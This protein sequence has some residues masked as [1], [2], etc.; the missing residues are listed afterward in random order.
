[1]LLR[2]TIR[3][4]PTPEQELLFRK[5]AGVAR[6]AYNFYISEQ[7]RTYQEYLT[8]NK[9]GNK[10]ISPNDVK[11][12]INNILKPTIEYQWLK[13]VGCNV[14]KQGVTDAFNAYKKFYN[15]KSNKPK[16]HSKRKNRLSFYVNYESLTK[17]N[18]GF[19]GECIGFIK[20]SEA[21]PDLINQKHYS[22][23]R[24]YYDNKYWYLSIAIDEPIVPCELT[25]EKLGIDLGIKDL[26]ICSNNK[27]YKNINKTHRV[28][29]IKKKLK[30]AQKKYSRKVLYNIKAYDKNR[31]PI[32]NRSLDE[33]KNIQKQK[34]TIQLLNRRLANIRHNYLHQVTTEIVKT[35]PSRIV[36]EDL[37]IK[38]MMKNRHLSKSIGE[39]GLYCFKQMIQYKCLKYGIEFC[40]VPTFYPSSKTCSHCGNIK[41]DLKL[42]DRIYY[43][44]ECG[45][46]IDRD[47]NAAINLANYIFTESV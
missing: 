14:I 33:C 37:N 41:K 2:K 42:S 4:K 21:L 24:I 38:G 6:W 29:K 12:Y 10:T 36:M 11:K 35:K 5:S 22:D 3:L 46:I 17:R 18:G 1:M 8:N 28:K 34:Y 44:N 15:G 16:Y 47:Y 43:C 20:T 19:H 39:Q 7:E 40:Q 31:K 13:D 27:K 9:T 26:A 32:Y 23:P 25:D 30:R 45:L